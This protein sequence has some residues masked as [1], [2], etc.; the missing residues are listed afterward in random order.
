MPRVVN[1]D[2]RRQQ[3][4]RVARDLIL[5]QG[6]ERVTVREIATL[7]GYSTAVV[8]HYFRDKKELM[9]LV[10]TDTQRRA[11]AR[12]RR[13][14]DAGLPVL[15]GLESLLPRDDESRDFWRVWFAF[16]SMTLTHE[17]FRREQ[18]V[19][20]RRTVDMIAELLGRA[21]LAAAT[22]EARLVQCQRLF[23]LV[24]GI[25]TQAT[26]DPRQ[27]PLRRQRAILKAELESLG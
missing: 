20:A 19:Q 5:R 10:F 18:V 8:S 26:H 4:A 16:W 6:I 11:E 17:D 25:A 24:S 13:A 22:A 21:G 15:E 9:F 27:W 2:E 12:F 14:I 3:V 23:A 7:A 1:H